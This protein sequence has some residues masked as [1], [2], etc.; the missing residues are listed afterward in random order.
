MVTDLAIPG[1]VAAL[2]SPRIKAATAVASW[3]GEDPA[4][5]APQSDAFGLLLL[6]TVVWC[7]MQA[8][9]LAG[10]VI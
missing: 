9:K 7:A 5:F 6:A 3:S 1:V 4:Q 8:L 10:R 2:A